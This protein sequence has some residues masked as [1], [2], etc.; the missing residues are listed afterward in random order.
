[1]EYRF[2][3]PKMQ[4]VI[5]PTKG[6]GFFPRMKMLLTSVRQWDVVENWFY[7]LP[8]GKMIMI[9]A[10]FRFDGASIPKPL[11]FLAG[12]VALLALLGWSISTELALIMAALFIFAGIALSPVGLLLVAGLVHDFAYRFG[13]LWAYDYQTGKFDKYYHKYGKRLDYDELFLEVN[14]SVNG[15]IIT[16]RLA[17]CLLSMFG[18][19]AWTK[20]RDRNAEEILPMS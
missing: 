6:K 11:Y 9:P 19:I 20:N 17:A 5:I 3:M 7:M 12:L 14:L 2:K 13:Y 18:A 10:G 1:M 8:N 4:P 16:D 15:M